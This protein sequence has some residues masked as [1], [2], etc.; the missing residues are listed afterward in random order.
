MHKISLGRW[1]VLLLLL[2]GC[3]V[4]QLF[5]SSKIKRYKNVKYEKLKLNERDLVDIELFS[6]K[7]SKK[8]TI[9]RTKSLWD[10]KGEGQAELVKTLDKRNGKEKEF[11]NALN[12]SYMKANSLI[13]DYTNLNLKMIFSISKLRNYAK[14]A[15]ENKKD[16]TKPVFS[17]ADRIAYLKFV[18][19]RLESTPFKF[20]SWNKFETEYKTINIG[21]VTFDQNFSFTGGINATT[22]DSSSNTR[23][24]GDDTVLSSG[25]NVLNPTLSGTASTNT[26]EF[27]KISYRYLALNG[28]LT[29]DSIVIEQEGVREI[30]L[31]GNVVVDVTLKFD[32]YSTDIADFS[33]TKV[34]NEMG[35]VPAK[36]SLKLN[37]VKLPYYDRLQDLYLLLD[38]EYVYRHVTNRKGQKTFYEW[39]DRI[40]YYEGSK[41]NSTFKVLSVNDYLPEFYELGGYWY[42]LSEKSDKE[43]YYHLKLYDE[44]RETAKELNTS[45]YVEMVQFLD[46]LAERT[47]WLRN[48]ID[49]TK[50]EL[51]RSIVGSKEKELLAKL[52]ELKNTYNN[53]IQIDKYKLVVYRNTKDGDAKKIDGFSY[54]D[55]DNVRSIIS[56][57][58]V[59]YNR[60]EILD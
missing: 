30:D 34:K 23:V 19:K 42:E 12:N 25:A 21:D 24:T 43:E 60:T 15:E 4:V 53:S 27:Q 35:K 31:A 52:K 40:K 2:S 22:T 55:F 11:L 6:S 3:S 16:S 47:L 41:S 44:G 54:D 7:I 13:R 5:E 50:A 51:S 38:Y 20:V 46:W 48:Q 14:L 26:K 1:L 45:N 9:K 33:Y 49:E 29:E 57:Y 10:L 36:V 28:S 8:P 59:F 39:D 32:G 56:P 17:D 58:P 37:T 18:V